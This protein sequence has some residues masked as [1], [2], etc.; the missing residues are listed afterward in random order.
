MNRAMD[1]DVEIAE[2]VRDAS[3][4]RDALLDIMV[5]NDMRVASDDEPWQRWMRSVNENCFLGRRHLTGISIPI[6]LSMWHCIA[7]STGF[8]ACLTGRG[9]LSAISQSSCF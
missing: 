5:S 1:V 4:Q 2:T 6:S 9:V 7:I 3:P 8:S